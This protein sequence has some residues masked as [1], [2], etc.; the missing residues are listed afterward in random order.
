MQTQSWMIAAALGLTACAGGAAPAEEGEAPSNNKQQPPAVVRII[1]GTFAMGSSEREP[2]HADGEAFHE[3]T[4]TRHLL[5]QTT[6]VTQA[7]WAQLIPNNPSTAQGCE[8]CPVES[9]NWWD[10]LYY[11]NLRS[12]EDGLR[13]CY[14]LG[15]C[16]GR[17]GVDLR[18][19]AAAFQG[20]DCEGWR[21]PT[22]AEW[23]YLARA[24]TRTATYQGDL[25]DTLC[26]DLGLSEIA[27]YCGS[28][29]ERP[30]PVAT[31]APNAWG[32]FDTS[33]N[34]WEW[35]WDWYAPMSAAPAVDPLG[36]QTGEARV[37]RGGG[38]FSFAPDCRAARRG[39]A[40][41]DER[42]ADLGFRAVRTLLPDNTGEW[43]EEP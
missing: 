14:G 43:A 4:L 38:W 22:E 10:A 1:P 31:R 5:V 3:V 20:L 39:A 25:T 30:Q 7:Q 23:E 11:L 12:A 27:W 24:G 37:V 15:A 41:P 32:L 33:G 13:P 36:P 35:T 40:G 26:G 18:C 19:E 28:A 9:V 42:S 34:V 29:P 16:E 21:L 2:G 8:G 17:P 6:E